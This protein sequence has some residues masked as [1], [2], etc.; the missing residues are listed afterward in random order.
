MPLTVALCI[1]HLQITMAYAYWKAQRAEET[2]VFELFFRKCP[3][4]GEY[5]VFAGL[6]QV[7]AF[8]NSFKFTLQDVEYLRGAPS[9]Q[10]A[11]PAFFDYLLTLDCSEVCVWALTPGCCFC[12]AQHARMRWFLQPVLR[13]VAHARASCV[14]CVPRGCGCALLGSARLDTG[15]RARP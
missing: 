7:L 1:A 6:E 10:N 8:L 9:F 13:C 5:V 4:K 2:A 3:F 14:S 12:L 15:Y 11:D